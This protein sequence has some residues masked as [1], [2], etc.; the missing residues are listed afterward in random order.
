MNKGDLIDAVATSSGESKAAAGRVLEAF[1]ETVTGQLKKG[2]SVTL[3]GFGSFSVTK[4]AAREGR[5]P[6]T[7]ET[8]KIKASKVAKFSPGAGLKSVLNPTKK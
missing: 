4:R 1:L 6:R 2:E 5:N 3:V 8:I 7:G